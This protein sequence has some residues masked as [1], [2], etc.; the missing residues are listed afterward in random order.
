M[1]VNYLESV[2]DKW[3]NENAVTSLDILKISGV[4]LEIY[5]IFLS[6]LKPID[7]LMQNQK[8]MDISRQ[9][10]QIF[11]N[12]DFLN[13]LVT[14]VLNKSNQ[15]SVLLITIPGATCYSIGYRLGAFT[16]FLFGVVYK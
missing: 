5:L 6:V 16:R 10:F 13:T 8:Y 7:D 15:M 2:R 3:I 11:S 1:G 9:I 12:K 4:L 14:N